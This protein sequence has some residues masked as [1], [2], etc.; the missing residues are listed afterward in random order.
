MPSILLHRRAQ[1][2]LSK[3]LCA[4]GSEG[5]GSQQAGEDYIPYCNPNQHNI[6]DPRLEIYVI[7]YDGI[8]SIL[9]FEAC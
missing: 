8:V 1:V 5:P 7:V 4:R 9:S 2:T 3:L 6:E